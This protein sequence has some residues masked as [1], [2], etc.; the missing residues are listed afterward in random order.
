LRRYCC[1]PSRFE[2]QTAKSI[3]EAADSTRCASIFPRRISPGLCLFVPPKR[4]RGEC[5]VPSAPAAS[6]AKV[7]VGMHTS[8][9]SEFTGKRPA[10]PRNGLRLIPRSPWRPGFLATIAGG[11]LHRL[12]TSVGVSGPHGFAVRITRRSSKAH[13]RPPHPAP[14]F[15]TIASAPL[16]VQDGTAYSL[17]CGF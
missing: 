6:C 9:H 16:A 12:D 11:L 17:I 5:R 8:I 3:S 4:G 7:V 14:T 10:S 1:N 15:V 2:F 13:P